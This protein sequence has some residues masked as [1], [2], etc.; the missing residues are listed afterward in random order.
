MNPIARRRLDVW[1]REALATRHHGTRVCLALCAALLLASC[2]ATIPR[3]S[4]SAGAIGD[5]LYF[6][7]SIPGG[8]SVSDQDWDRFVDEIVVPAFPDGHTVW[9]A[10]GAWRDPGGRITREATFVLELVHDD[11]PGH[12]AA[13]EAIIAAYK[14]RFHQQSVMWAR[15]AVSVRF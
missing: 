2:G 8:G 6:G 4:G 13:I 1:N 11:A 10:D 5:R 12:D 14:S 9:R 15:S 3:Q 7:R